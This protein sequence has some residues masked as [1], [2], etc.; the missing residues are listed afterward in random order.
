MHAYK[1]TDDHV[2]ASKHHDASKS[3]KKKAAL[4]MVK[5]SAKQAQPHYEFV[6]IAG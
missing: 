5:K 4:K 6:G 1:R 3:A 2:T